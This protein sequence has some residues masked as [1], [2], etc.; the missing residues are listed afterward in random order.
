MGLGLAACQAGTKSWAEM[1]CAALSPVFMIWVMV[2][3]TKRQDKD[4]AERNEGN[5]KYQA[6]MRS[7]W[8]LVPKLW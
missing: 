8:A 1:S 6:W 5:D 3:A 7:T 4:Q 2:G